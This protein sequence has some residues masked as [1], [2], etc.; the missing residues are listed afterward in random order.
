MFVSFIAENQNDRIRR[1]NNQ[2]TNSKSFVVFVPD[3]LV[4]TNWGDSCQRWGRGIKVSI[5]HLTGI[6]LFKD[7]LLFTVGYSWTG[8]I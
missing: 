4:I 3:T 7:H 5:T 6:I 8:K 2:V 1:K